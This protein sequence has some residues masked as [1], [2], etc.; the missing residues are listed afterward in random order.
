MREAFN[1]KHL[2]VKRKKAKR[3]KKKIDVSSDSSDDEKEEADRG[4]KAQSMEG[5]SQEQ[6]VVTLAKAY[7]LMAGGQPTF[8][9]QPYVKQFKGLCNYC[10]EQGHKKFDYPN[11]KAKEGNENGDQQRPMC[12]H[13]NRNTHNADRCW[14]LK[15][16]ASNRP[17]G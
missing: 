15:K 6:L 3:G 1:E 12:I 17:L 7:S 2:S 14:E 9:Y 4:L 10:G 16:N 5:L 8:R 13:C 11:R